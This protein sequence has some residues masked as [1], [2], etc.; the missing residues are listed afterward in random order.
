MTGTR[1]RYVI[2]A[3]VLLLALGSQTAWSQ[4]T[5]LVCDVGQT[6]CKDS[7]THWECGWLGGGAACV[8]C[9]GTNYIQKFCQASQV[10]T[11]ITESVDTATC[12]N[13]YNGTCTRPAP[14]QP[15][16]WTGGVI[17]GPCTVF[18]CT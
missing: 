14:S 18:L 2:A 13:K 5:L 17:V 4:W 3:I 9:D 8:W 11:C 6:Q 15:W 7:T 10:Q 12:G 1:A 16:R